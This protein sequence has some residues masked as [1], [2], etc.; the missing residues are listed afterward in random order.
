MRPP[1]FRQVVLRSDKPDAHRR[2]RA[3]K[4]GRSAA[5]ADALA[6]EPNRPLIRGFIV[7]CSVATLKPG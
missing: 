4:K 7:N 1:S 3:T 2:G 5:L 6:S